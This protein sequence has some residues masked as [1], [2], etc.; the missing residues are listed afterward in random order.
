MTRSRLPSRPPVTVGFENDGLQW[1]CKTPIMDSVRN[2]CLEAPP[3]CQI[4]EVCW[5]N[6]SAYW[7]SPRVTAHPECTREN[8]CSQRFGEETAGLF[9]QSVILMHQQICAIHFPPGSSQMRHWEQWISVTKTLN[10]PDILRHICFPASSYTRLTPEKM[11]VEG[12]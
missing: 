1:R 6:G 10:Y 4:V 2:K 3:Q 11:K 7:L 5:I 9:L 12:N 8:I